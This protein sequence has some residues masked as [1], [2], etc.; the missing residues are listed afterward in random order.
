MPK[1]SRSRTA[2]KKLPDKL[3]TKAVPDA[4]LAVSINL[5]IPKG[6]EKSADKF[7]SEALDHVEKGFKKFMKKEIS[8]RVE[9]SND[10]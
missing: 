4:K 2:Y 3:K 10:V 5:T 1:T 6:M 7:I 8:K 9:D